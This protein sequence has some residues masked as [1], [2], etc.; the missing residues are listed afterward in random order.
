[1]KSEPIDHGAVKGFMAS[2]AAFNISGESQARVWEFIASARNTV[3]GSSQR[4]TVKQALASLAFRFKD[5][6][7]RTAEEPMIP[8]ADKVTWLHLTDRIFQDHT[9]R[10]YSDG[11]RSEFVGALTLG[12][13]DERHA[14]AVDIEERQLRS[15][16]IPSVSSV[17]ANPPAQPRWNPCRQ[18]YAL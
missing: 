15:E 5:D 13:L 16:P 2:L 6:V 12:T 9:K 14:M 10:I 18:W 8:E 7:H 11:L 17:S 3:T 1:M 4:L